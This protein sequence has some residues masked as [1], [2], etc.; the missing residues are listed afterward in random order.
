MRTH[1]LYL[2]LQ[3]FCLEEHLATHLPFLADHL[4]EIGHV[5]PT[6][7]GPTSL[8]SV[9][10]SIDSV[11]VDGTTTSSISSVVVGGT[12]SSISSVIVGG[13]TSSISSVVVVGGTTSSISSISDPASSNPS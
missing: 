5:L 10:P 6:A 2:H 8:I 12:T 7:V 4:L 13:A 1:L 11:D 9:T 3:E